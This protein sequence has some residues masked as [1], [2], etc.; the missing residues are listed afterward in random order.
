MVEWKIDVNFSMARSKALEA[1]GMIKWFDNN[2]NY[3]VLEVGPTI[4]FSSA[5]H[6]TV[7]EYREGDKICPLMGTTQLCMHLHYIYGSATSSKVGVNAYISA[8]NKKAMD[9]TLLMGR[10]LCILGWS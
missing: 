10:K 1:M 3:S 2:F 4:K 7:E 6:K 5:F 8:Q 9:V